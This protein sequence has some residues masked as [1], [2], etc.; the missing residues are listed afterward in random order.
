MKFI[1]PGLCHGCYDATSNS[2]LR[3]VILAGLNDELLQ[4]VCGRHGQVWQRA[5]TDRIRVDTVDDDRVRSGTKSIDIDWGI[6]AAQIGRILN[7]AR[8]PGRESQQL[9]EIPGR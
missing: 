6:A 7:R 8:C 1:R 2:S 4:R 5:C 3:R 9:L